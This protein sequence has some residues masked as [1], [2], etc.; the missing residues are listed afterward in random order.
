MIPFVDLHAYIRALV[1]TVLFFSTCLSV[2]LTFWSFKYKFLLPKIISPLCGVVCTVF[3]LPYSSFILYFR[4]NPSLASQEYSGKIF[5]VSAAAVIAVSLLM[6]GTLV[7]IA[8]FFYHQSRNSISPFSVKESV[9]KLKTGIC[10]CYK[11]GMIKLINHRMDE[12]G[13]IITG[14]EVSNALEFIDT[15]KNGMFQPGVERLSVSED[16]IILRLPD[17]SVWSFSIEEIASM[18]EITAADATDIYR[19]TEELKM[20]NAELQLM[21]DRLVKYGENVDELTKSR[22]RLETKHRIHAELGKALLATRLFLQ[23]N[24][25]N[26]DEIISMWKR[27]ITALGIENDTRTDYDILKG[28]FVAADAV[29]IKIEMTGEIPEKEKIKRLFID[30]TAESLTNAVRHADAEK[31]EIT[32]SQDLFCYCARFSNSVKSPVEEIAEG[33]GLSSIRRKTELLGGRMTVTGAPEFMLTL[34][35]PK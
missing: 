11:N 12:L 14:N 25:G 27:N 1:L 30:A 29:G 5:S 23:N 20:S 31:L 33:G 4:I 24:D 19:V 7:L 6:L 21:N 10:F 26:A 34:T 8:Y 22:E 2:C 15:I 18:Y 32:F 35:V 9:D 16:R 13:R 3:L 17:L 28:L